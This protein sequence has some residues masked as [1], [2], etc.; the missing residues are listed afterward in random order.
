M[1][2]LKDFTNGK[3]R[4]SGWQLLR[5]RLVRVWLV[6][7][8]LAGMFAVPASAQAPAPD[9]ETYTGW[10]R[11]A[12]VAAQ[13]G[14][15]LGLEQVARNLIATSAVQTPAGTPVPVDNGWLREALDTPDPDLPQ[16]ATRLGAL[17][18]ALS[19]PASVAPADAEQR[20]RAILNR[21][22]FAAAVSQRDNLLIRLL[23][24]LLRLLARLFD[25]TG[26]GPAVGS[27][28]NWIIAILG[29]LLL[30][31][32]LLY[33]ALNMRRSLVGEARA[34]TEDDP[35]ANLTANIALQQ[36]STLARDG[37]YR[38]AV[39]YLYLSSLLWLDE[40][41]LLRYDRA[42]TNREYLERLGPDAELRARLVPIVDT[43]DR[44][45]YGYAPL[46]AEGFAAYQRQVDD[47][48]RVR[49]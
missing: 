21:P 34:A 13:R 37:D 3:P 8:I 46:D 19:Q 41:G 10:L 32:V 2:V 15:R 39:R 35:E 33:L 44:V 27:V 48:R 16:I 9:L 12:Y 26:V 5:A 4:T 11:E 43:F 6:G 28:I 17:V 40:R 49:V 30:A 22:P 20:L 7:C 47:L 31:G 1:L 38:T 14:D 36:A 45:W 24:W 18:D 23:D 25:A 42:L 29:S